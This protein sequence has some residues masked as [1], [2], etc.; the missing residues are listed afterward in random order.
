[1]DITS[2]KTQRILSF[3]PYANYLVPFIWLYNIRYICR[4]R[5]EIVKIVLQMV[6]CIVPLL[7]L[8]T[9][10]LKLAYA[11]GA[12]IRLLNG[13]LIPLIADTFLIKMQD[14]DVVPSEEETAARKKR[15]KWIV[16]F[17]VVFVVTVVIVV[18]SVLWMSSYHIEDT[19][20]DDPSLA[21]VTL[22]DILLNKA[23]YVATVFERTRTGG[24][25][26][27]PSQLQEYDAQSIRYSCKTLSGVMT[28]H[29]TVAEA[30]K[31]VLFVTTELT[32]GNLELVVVVDGE[33]YCHVPIGKAQRVVV[34]NA[35][36]KLVEVRVGAESARVNVT[37]TR[38][39]R[40][41]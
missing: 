37:V 19:N 21:V 32:A 6:L 41:D 10:T 1:M 17:A 13:Y 16:I 18:A 14:I 34:E 29:A 20:G 2:I 12:F 35:I 39:Y 7:I 15:R 8:Q 5:R 3:I 38:N 9:V 26:G 23:G 25:S 31:L 4:S 24:S 27:V 40:Y 28:I 22:D 36:G 11:L 33:Y 30:D